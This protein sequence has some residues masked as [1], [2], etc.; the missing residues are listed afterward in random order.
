MIR[1]KE[2]EC[3]K[4]FEFILKNKQDQIAQVYPVFVSKTLWLQIGRVFKGF[5]KM[6][7][8]IKK[9]CTE[10]YSLISILLD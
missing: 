7:A 6:I 3:N 5:A 1:I 4:F 2:F 10:T 9:G 8:K